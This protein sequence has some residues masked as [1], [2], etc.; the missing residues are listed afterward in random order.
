[1][2]KKKKPKTRGP[3]NEEIRTTLSSIANMGIGIPQ[4][5]VDWQN[6]GKNAV[7]LARKTFEQK[8]IECGK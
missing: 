3:S 4:H 6:I 5:M 7:N 8:C 2:A 1:M